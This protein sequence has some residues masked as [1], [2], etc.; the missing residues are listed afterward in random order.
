MFVLTN[1]K[2]A[3]VTCHLYLTQSPY[4]YYTQRQKLSNTSFVAIFSEHVMNLR[5]KIMSRDM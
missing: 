1:N 5:N 3:T 2:S 4:I